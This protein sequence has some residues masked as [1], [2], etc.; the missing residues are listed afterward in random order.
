MEIGSPAKW[1]TY[2][3]YQRFIMIDTN[4]FFI[5]ELEFMDEPVPSVYLLSYHN[6]SMN[7]LLVAKEAYETSQSYRFKS[8]THYKNS[9]EFLIKIREALRGASKEKPIVSDIG[10]FNSFEHYLQTFYG[11]NS[12]ASLKR[13]QAWNYMRLAENWDIVEDLKLQESEACYRLQITLKIITWGIKKREAGYNLKELDHHLYFKEREELA[14]QQER[15]S[16]PTYAQLEKKV[17]ELTYKL[18]EL[19]DKLQE[20]NQEIIRLRLRCKHF[21]SE[22][23]MLQESN[24]EIIRLRRLL[25]LEESFAL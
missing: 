5:E 1:T 13:S 16:K 14:A 17:D 21:K 19:S 22:R 24:Q 8:L 3:K 10:V 20:S 4:D 18:E 2:Q 7:E 25:S 6:A 23:V 15:T 9:G 12:N 11:K